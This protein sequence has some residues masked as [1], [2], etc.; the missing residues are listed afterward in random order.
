MLQH[1]TFLTSETLAVL[2]FVQLE[3]QIA[4]YCHAV[5]T[6]HLT[7]TGRLLLTET[8]SWSIG[9][10]HL[11]VPFSVLPI[12]LSNSFQSVAFPLSVWVKTFRVSF[13]TRELSLPSPFK[14][15]SSCF[16]I[17]RFPDGLSSFNLIYHYSQYARW[18]RPLGFL[19]YRTQANFQLIYCALMMFNTL[20]DTAPKRRTSYSTINEYRVNRSS[21]L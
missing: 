11:Q 9:L 20:F 3:V 5:R 13:M 1:H 4:L 15:C 16:G 21:V 12:S 8:N 2:R 19:L 14:F 17:V 10:L 7:R 18:H 6:D